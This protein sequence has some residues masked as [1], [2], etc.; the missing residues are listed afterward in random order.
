MQVFRERGFEGASVKDLERSTGISSGSLYN[1][2]GGKEDIFVEAL[3]HYNK[4]VVRERVERFLSNKSPIKGLTS[5]FLSLLPNTP[6]GL[7]G[8]LLTNSAVE[9]GAGKSIATAGVHEG[10]TIL[11]DG[12]QR[13]IDQL[14]L[15][16]GDG[17]RS[18]FAKSHIHSA[19]KLLTLYQGI[20]VLVRFGQSPKE[21]SAFIKNEIKQLTGT[22][23]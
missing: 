5:L 9:F 16:N 4:T 15:E 14:I 1:S 6:D 10:F 11:E 13:S 23:K 8:C 18:K 2:F 17:V 7:H 20:L 22:N 3:G 19:K 12:F 21:L